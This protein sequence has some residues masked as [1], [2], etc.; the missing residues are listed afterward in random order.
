MSDSSQKIYT[1]DEARELLPELRPRLHEMQDIWAELEPHREE[2]QKIGKRTDNGGAT[3]PNAG[4]YFRLIHQLKEKLAFFGKAGIEIK[5]ISTGLVDFPSLRDG[6]VMYLCW[7]VDE[8][9]ITHWHETDGGF[10]GRQPLE[11]PNS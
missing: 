8:E 7:R 11:G 2:A 4:E 3:L 9:T 10:A 5:D 6:R 1:V